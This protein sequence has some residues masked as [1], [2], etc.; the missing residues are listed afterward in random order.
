MTSETEQYRAGDS[1]IGAKPALGTGGRDELHCPNLLGSSPLNCSRELHSDAKA[2][3][4]TLW[5]ER[6]TMR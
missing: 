1:T 2:P 5:G 6:D 4:F 3:H